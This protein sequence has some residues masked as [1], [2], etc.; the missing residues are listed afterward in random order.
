MRAFHALT[1]R[2]F[3]SETTGA[4]FAERRLGFVD[5]GTRGDREPERQQAE[6]EEQRASE[7][8]HTGH[9]R[10]FGEHGFHPNA[11]KGPFS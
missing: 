9:K 2:A 3:L 4:L 10:Q 7:Q 1:T 11:E 6:E 8:Q 5:L